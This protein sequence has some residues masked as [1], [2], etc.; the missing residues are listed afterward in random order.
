M[1]I[2]PDY[3]VE[4]LEDIDFELL[5]SKGKNILMFDLDST[6]MPSKAGEYLPKTQELLKKLKENFIVVVLSNNTKQ[7]YIDKVRSVSDFEV[8]SHAK[9]PNTKILMKYLKDNNKSV[10]E[11][12]LIGDRPLTDVLCGKL[13]KVTTILVDSITKDKE[14][15]IVRFARWL[16]RLTI[17]K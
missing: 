13:A 12:V 16:E 2:K 10:D 6:L 11:V 7:S 15:K 8:I 9:K 3:N 17:R 5:K 1:F 14:H 4:K